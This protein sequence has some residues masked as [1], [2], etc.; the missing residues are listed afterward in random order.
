ML[1]SAAAFIHHAIS[2][3]SVLAQIQAFHEL[4]CRVVAIELSSECIRITG[5]A[6]AIYLSW[7]LSFKLLL[8]CSCTR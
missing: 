6:D 1:Q 7:Q 4:L 2:G 3:A 8:S 5:E